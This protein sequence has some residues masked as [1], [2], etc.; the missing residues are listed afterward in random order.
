ML[1]IPQSPTHAGKPFVSI[2]PSPH[3]AKRYPLGLP[4]SPL[5]EA[6]SFRTPH[7]PVLIPQSPRLPYPHF[8]NAKTS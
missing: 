6:V 7:L 4:I 1:F 2:S 3:Y 5:C 8:H